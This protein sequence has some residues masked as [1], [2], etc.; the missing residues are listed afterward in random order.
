MKYFIDNYYEV[1]F[2]MKYSNFYSVY[3]NSRD[4]A[5]HLLI[6]QNITSLPISIQSMCQNLSIP[7]LDFGNH[8]DLIHE[9]KLEP[10]IEN[11]DGFTILINEHPVIFYNKEITPH[12]RLRFTVAHELGHIMLQHLKVNSV[13]CR[14]G[15]TLWNAGE[16]APPNLIESAANVFASRL[17]APAFLL[18]ELN[19]K[20]IEE[21]M[22]LTGL[23]YT[24]SEI[25][26]KRL[27]SLKQRNKFYRSPLEKQVY[28]QFEDFI[29]HYYE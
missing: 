8:L 6:D 20:T 25:R 27:K 13:A 7:L 15:V 11:N 23:S 1:I 10:Y 22:D 29:K 5:W 2:S 28:L 9:F 26:L 4:M 17:L 3:Q 24:A 18:K 19:L 14:S 12:G 21:I 16:I